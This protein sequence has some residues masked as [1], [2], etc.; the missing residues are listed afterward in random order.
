MQTLVVALLYRIVGASA[1]VKSYYKY[2]SFS[3]FGV[4]VS[5]TS[6][7]VF[8]DSGK[9]AVAGCHNRV[10]AWNVKKGEVEFT[11]TDEDANATSVTVIARINGPRESVFA[12]G[13]EDGSIRLWS[14][15]QSS[16]TVTFNGHK[17]AVTC[18]AG[19]KDGSR[20]ASGSKDTNVVVWDTIQHQGLFRLHGHKGVVT[21]LNFL[22]E[23]STRYPNLNHLVSTSKDSLL[24]IWDLTTQTCIDTVIAS[25]AELYSAAV[26][27]EREY[28]V[29]GGSDPEMKV[30]KLNLDVI[31]ARLQSADSSTNSNSLELIGNV[32]RHS[33]DRLIKVAF[34]GNGKHLVA[35][36]NDKTVEVYKFRTLE[37]IR[38]RTHRRQQRGKKQTN[39]KQSTVDDL[40]TL[41]HLTRARHRIKSFDLY[42]ADSEGVS[43]SLLLSTQANTIELHSCDLPKKDEPTQIVAELALPGHRSG[44][45]CIALSG[46]NQ[47]I[48]SGSSNNLKIWNLVK[49]TCLRT[50]EC[51]FCVCMSFAQ[52]D[53][54]L[55]VGTKSGALQIFDLASSNLVGQIQAHEGAIFSMHMHPNK[56]FLLTGGTDKDVKEW[57]IVSDEGLLE[58]RRTLRMTDHVTCVRYTPNEKL[59]AVAQLDC[60][61][62]LYFH[63]TLKFFLSLYGHKLPVLSMDISSDSTLIATGSA[64]KSVKLW[65]LDFGDC[66][67]SLLAH[68]DSVTAVQF[69]FG[70]HYFFTASK[71]GLVKYWDGDA[72]ECVQ[73]LG[74]QTAEIWGL[75]VGKFGE[76]IVSAGESRA[77]VIWKRSNEHLFLEEERE[78]QMEKIYDASAVEAA[79]RVD[80]AIGAHVDGEENEK[81]A[82]DSSSSAAMHSLQSLKASEKILEALQVF[83]EERKLLALYRQQL[84]RW[85]AGGCKSAKPLVYQRNPYI[86]AT[87]NLDMTSEEYALSVLERIKSTELEQSIMLLGFSSVL[88]LLELVYIWTCKVSVLDFVIVTIMKHMCVQQYAR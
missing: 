32:V 10:V 13:Y 68:L 45:R 44:I 74:G 21:S 41:L 63:D 86:I 55:Y 20:I 75:A 33:A 52:D 53:R 23:S 57:E 42:R 29:T 83:S 37:E 70:T 5:P 35:Q 65:G 82:G 36:A 59:I 2:Q 64:D 72:W 76:Y 22:E 56:R 26:N 49:G 62:K 27:I 81:E 15:G 80:E 58:S 19:N 71:D 6:N 31:Q 14:L 67:R 34:D 48:A 4:V 85:H 43:F 77:L 78:R 25:R 60:T 7:V 46:D 87:G 28:L 88:I 3:T 30:W 47:M 84:G 8:D 1:M 66:H 18:I 24:K 11:W 40:F 73:E 16:P 9:L 39:E 61:V 12:V 79:N 54:V 51:G 17:S 50:I 38:K 69:V